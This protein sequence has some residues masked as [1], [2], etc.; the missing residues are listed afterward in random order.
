MKLLIIGD[1]HLRYTAPINRKETFYN[2][3][4][5]KLEEIKQIQ[6]QNN[7]DDEN[8][9]CLGDVFDDFI[10]DYAEKIIFDVILYI[11]GWTFLVGNHDC[12]EKNGDIRGTTFGMLVQTGIINV[13]KRSI[14]NKEFLL[15][16]YQYYNRQNIY[17]M[18]FNINDNMY[19]TKIAFIHD[20]IVP[21]KI[22]NKYHAKDVVT[23]ENMKSQ[24][25]YIFCGHYHYDYDIT[26]NGT[27]FINPG[28]L[29]RKTIADDDM[30]RKV[31]V[32]I[33]DL[34]KID[35]DPVQYIYL[36]SC[37]DYKD[38]FNINNDD[39]IKKDFDSQFIQKLQNVKLYGNTFDDVINLLKDNKVDNDVIEYVD[40][41][42]Q[43]I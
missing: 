3:L 22:A 17:N 6:L 1:L 25:D 42:K 19:K 5:N 13:C 43:N 27:R 8:V 38:V 10:I 31:K 23:C 14:I 35:N 4:L 34:Y 9:I 36:K 29:L 7:I 20:Y 18:N 32:C 37:K 15:D 12:K 28:A 21:N 24:Y 2:E 40:A 41:M 11:K 39:I 26:C 16:F 33:F 30:K